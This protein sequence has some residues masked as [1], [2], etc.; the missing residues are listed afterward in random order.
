MFEAALTLQPTFL[1]AQRVDGS[2]AGVDDSV[3]GAG[4]HDGV[5]DREAGVSGNVQ[6]PT[7]LA[8]KRQA[9]GPHLVEKTAG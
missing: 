1:D 9:H 4:G 3:F 5:V 8:D 7:E 6:L 2:V